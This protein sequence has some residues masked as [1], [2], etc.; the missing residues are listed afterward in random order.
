MYI[1]INMLDI[2]LSILYICLSQRLVFQLLKFK[3]MKKFITLLAGITCLMFL[4]LDTVNAQWTTVGTDIHNTNTG[5]VGISTTAPATLLDVAKSMT[6]PSI[7]VYNLGGAGGASYQM[8]DFT[9]GADWKFKA[10]GTGGFKIRDH[11]MGLDV[12]T[13]EQSAAANAIYVKAGGNVGLGSTA[14]LEKLQV[15]GAINL[16]TTAGTN[17][18]TIRWNGT[19][20]QGRIPGAWVDL[21][22]RSRVRA[23]QVD[24]TVQIIPPATPTPVNFT[25]DT[26]LPAGYDQLAEFTLA[27]A[28][29]TPTPVENAYFTASETGYYQ[30]NA[31]CEFQVPNT[32]GAVGPDSHVSIAIYSGPAPGA[33]TSYA[34]GNNL[35]IGYFGIGG[36]P[37]PLIF[38]NAPNVSDVVFLPAGSIISIWVYHTALVP[39]M[40]IQ[41][42]DRLYVSIH[43]VS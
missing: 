34:V 43:R 21:D 5:N 15:S 27:P 38:N 2:W 40:L 19:H 12:M 26:P 39:M 13:I 41:G 6:E 10:T 16:G 18:G 35:Q 24:P 25:D 36:Q 28:A 1:Y 8:K 23:Y 30:V 32:P 3:I 20:F 7:R 33:T 14:P 42:T 29:S 17:T 4:S 11:A 9:S 31:R 22:V 37:T